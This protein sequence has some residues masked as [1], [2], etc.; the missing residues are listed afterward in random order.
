MRR[1]IE[2]LLSDSSAGRSS[3]RS[4][5]TGS[6]RAAEVLAEISLAKNL[7]LSPDSY[8]QLARAPA[9]PL[10]AAVWRESEA[11]LQRSNAFDFDDLLAFA[12]RLLAEHPHRLRGFVSAG[13]GCWSTSTRTPTTPRRAGRSARRSRR[14][15]SVRCGTTTS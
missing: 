9:A 10:I 11:E 15:T 13:G 7:L 8:E 12:V 4:P 3:G 6:R 14:A 2:W 1:V 5:T